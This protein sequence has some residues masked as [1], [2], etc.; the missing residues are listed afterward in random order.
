MPEINIMN[1]D[2]MDW[3]AGK[4]DGYYGLIINDPPYNI[5]KDT[6]D[7]IENYYDEVRRWLHEME[8]VLTDNGSMYFFHNDINQ[9]LEIMNIIKNETSFVIKQFITWSKIHESFP[10]S[11]YVHQRL[12]IDMMRNYYNGFTEYIL[13]LT[14]QDETGQDRDWETFMY[15]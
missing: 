1:C 2:C 7:K 8:R 14:F 4:P 5:E 10:N 9:L 15:F 13:Y 6:W 3:M 11:G 12:S